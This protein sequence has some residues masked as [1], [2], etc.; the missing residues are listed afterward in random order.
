VP[1]LSQIYTKITADIV[2]TE[3]TV[4]SVIL[5]RNFSFTT[6][7]SGPQISRWVGGMLLLLG[8]CDP[9]QYS[10]PKESLYLQS[11]LA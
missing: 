10:L 7:Y 1:R 4:I 3:H 2:I 5:K 9:G 8:K 11:S 6:D